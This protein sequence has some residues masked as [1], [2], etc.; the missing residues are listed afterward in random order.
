MDS[1]YRLVM[2]P[3]SVDD[4]LRLRKESGLSA[5]TREEAENGINGAW[6]AASVIHVESGETAGMGR[7]L[8]DGGWYFVIIDMAVLPRHQR[9]GIGDAIMTA[10]LERIRESS[11]GAQ[12]SL[13]ADPPG[14]R[15]YARHGF[16]ESAPSSIGMWRR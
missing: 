6:A 10:L 2:Q 9:K 7:V 15:L 16:V 1:A 8:G 5:R 11:P 4:Y 3:P 13:L 12:V 14:R